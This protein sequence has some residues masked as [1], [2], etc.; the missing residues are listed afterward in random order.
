MLCTIHVMYMLLLDI[1]DNNLKYEKPLWSSQSSHMFQPHLVIGRTDP[2]INNS[3]FYSPRVAEGLHKP[4]LT[5]RPFPTTS[6][7]L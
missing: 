6:R 4:M 7:H 5:L 3:S 1:A 2:C